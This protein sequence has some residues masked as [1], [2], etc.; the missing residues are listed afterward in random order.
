MEIANVYAVECTVEMEHNEFRIGEAQLG[1][2][3]GAELIGGCGVQNE[4]RA[5][6]TGRPPGGGLQTT[7]GGGQA[8]HCSI[9]HHFE[10]FRLAGGR[11][12][13]HVNHYYGYS[14]DDGFFS[15]R[16]EYPGDP[17]GPI[18]GRGTLWTAF[19]LFDAAPG[20]S[21][22]AG[23]WGIELI[24]DPEQPERVIRVP[25]WYVW[26]VVDLD[27]DGTAELLATRAAPQ[28]TGA[29]DYVLP[30]RTDVLRWNGTTLAPVFR[31]DGVAPVVLSIPNTPTRFA[32]RST[33]T[34]QTTV[35]LRDL[36]GHGTSEVLVEDRHGR[37]SFLRVFSVSARGGA[38]R[39]Q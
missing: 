1:P 16:P 6:R 8:A 38:V 29:P 10:S 9:H 4:R 23:Q 37:R 11:I 20:S 39:R 12:A 27:H 14:V 30:W 24:P 3:L 5:M 21:T 28:K 31:R 32:G 26:D 13:A 19:N 25:G 22:G 35:L 15:G 17:T 34:E 36:D 2:A 7:S 18:G 33:T